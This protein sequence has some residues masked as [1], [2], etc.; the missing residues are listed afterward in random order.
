VAQDFTN[1]HIEFEGML[2]YIRRLRI[3]SIVEDYH[4]PTVE[5]CDLTTVEDYHLVIVE[6]YDITII[7]VHH[8]VTVTYL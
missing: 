4:L 8:L 3:Q 5:D 7:E 6:D 2:E 1:F